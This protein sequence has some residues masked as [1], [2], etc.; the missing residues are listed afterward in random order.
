M[1]KIFNSARFVTQVTFSIRLEPPAVM[2][3]LGNILMEKEDALHALKPFQVASFVLSIHSLVRRFA[4][5]VRL[6]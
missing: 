4:L 2:E 3:E 1:K 5:L 6:S